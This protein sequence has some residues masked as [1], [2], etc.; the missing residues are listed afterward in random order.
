MKKRIT[1]IILTSVLVLSMSSCGN[2]ESQ[3][4]VEE[5]TA[6]LDQL[7]EDYDAL[8]EELKAAQKT[9]EE[10][11]VENEDAPIEQITKEET[12]EK[13]ETADEP[14]Y[15][16][17]YQ[18]AI[19]HTDEY[20]YITT[21]SIAEVKN[22][23]EADLYLPYGSYDL[24]TQDGS[25]VH[26]SKFFRPAPQIIAPGE[27][28]Y[29]FE[30]VYMD[31]GTPT[32]GISITPYIT[33]ETSKLKNYRLEISNTAIFDKEYGGIDVHGEVTNTS[34]VA[35]EYLD[36]M[37]VFFDSEGHSIGQAYDLISETLQPGET[38]GF[39]I[40]ASDLPTTITTADIAKYQVYAFPEQ[41]QY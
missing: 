37:I 26:S 41:Y 17:T 23:G 40:S 27:T 11:T 39:D 36:I 6:Q 3:Q 4:Q 2:S 34:D 31:E 13:S 7:Q 20:G 14:S 35:H 1:A 9:A 19:F 15:E 8:K 16:I 33:P 22:T 21:R 38:R 18:N 28:G 32:E 12:D 10:H 30:N 25:I 24:K 29:Y 5:L